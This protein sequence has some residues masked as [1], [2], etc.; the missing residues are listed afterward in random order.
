[1]ESTRI[2][3]TVEEINKDLG[4]VCI[5]QEP[6]QKIDTIKY[7]RTSTKIDG[8]P[9]SLLINSP[10]PILFT[11]NPLMFQAPEKFCTPMRQ[12]RSNNPPI[13][14]HTNSIHY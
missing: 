1:M 13:L 5:L 12:L 7:I 10:S 11:D 8:A 9:T 14:D 2:K 3:L 4:P 6:T